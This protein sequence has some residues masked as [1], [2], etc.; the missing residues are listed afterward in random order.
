MMTSLIEYTQAASRAGTDTASK[1]LDDR[2][3]ELA[4]RLDKS[5]QALAEFQR[6]NSGKLPGSEGTYFERIQRERDELEK[7]R[8]D[9][10]LARSKSERLH[11]QLT[12]ESPLA[13]DDPS[14]KQEPRPNSIDARIRD[15]H[16]ELDRLL[17]M[18]TEK[19]P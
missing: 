9:L 16:A 10:R 7:T 5:E 12:S 1:F 8:R 3:A 17:L 2:I 4:A 6:A 18:Y 19:H 13:L 11:Q 14:L 15:G